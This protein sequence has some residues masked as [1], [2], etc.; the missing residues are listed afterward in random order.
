MAFAASK[1]DVEVEAAERLQKIERWHDE[2]HN[3]PAARFVEEDS[4]LGHN[5]HRS[6]LEIYPCLHDDTNRSC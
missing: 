4:C 2:G 5:A 1:W 3:G 6:D